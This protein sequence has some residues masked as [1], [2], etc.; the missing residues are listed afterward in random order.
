MADP[1]RNPALVTDDY[2]VEAPT[3]RQVDFIV[4]NYGDVVVRPVVDSGI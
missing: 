1:V 4:D 3:E 2:G